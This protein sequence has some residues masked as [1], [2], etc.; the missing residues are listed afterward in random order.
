ME[1]AGKA[2]AEL[3]IRLLGNSYAVLV[4]AGPGNNGGDALVT[5][6]ILREHGYR[7]ST[8]LIGDS[9]RLPAD[10]AALQNWREDDGSILSAIPADGHWDLILTACIWNW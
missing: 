2:A 7:V 4:L 10:A 9:A 5:A 8:V 1:R 6:R 3:A